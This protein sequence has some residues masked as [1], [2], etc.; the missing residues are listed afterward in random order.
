MRCCSYVA[1]FAVIIVS[2]MATPQ[3]VQSSYQNTDAKNEAMPPLN[4]TENNINFETIPPHKT[5]TNNVPSSNSTIYPVTTGN[6]SNESIPAINIKFIDDHRKAELDNIKNLPTTGDAINT[7]HSKLDTNVIA[8]SASTD[9]ILLAGNTGRDQSQASSTPI[10]MSTTTQNTPKAAP[11]NNTSTITTPPSTTILTEM[12][13]V[14]ATTDAST[15]E[16]TQTESKLT[17]DLIKLGAES[18]KAENDTLTDDLQNRTNLATTGDA[19]NTDVNNVSDWN[20]YT[21]WGTAITPSVHF[22]VTALS[23]IAN[24]WLMYALH[25]ASTKLKRRNNEIKGYRSG[26][27]YDIGAT[28]GMRP[29]NKKFDRAVYNAKTFSNY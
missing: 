4:N 26:T 10:T 8:K 5:L 29:R 13:K 6:A 28:E 19:N 25:L 12:T 22:I 27:V 2:G 15:T 17:E 14:W 9:F 7:N 18:A 20:N 1:A 11:T 16:K 23:F 24:M 3:L 21:N